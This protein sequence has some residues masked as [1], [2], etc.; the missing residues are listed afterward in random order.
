MKMKRLKMLMLTICMLPVAL[1][2]T[3]CG[4]LSESQLR[5]VLEGME[6]EVNVNCG[7]TTPIMTIQSG[8]FQVV[9][10]TQV[11]T[12]VFGGPGIYAI[13]TFNSNMTDSEIIAELERGYGMPI[14]DIW[15]L[16]TLTLN[17][18]TLEDYKQREIDDVRN[19][20]D[21][22]M[23]IIANL[24]I[25]FDMGFTYTVDAFGKIHLRNETV[26]ATH[27]GDFLM[28]YIDGTI[29]LSASMWY[30]GQFVRAVVFVLE[31]V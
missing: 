11:R 26:A 2:L 14:E 20:F 21:S 27:F 25:F 29:N 30:D 12:D 4:G 19:T 16:N 9:E 17:P 3:A 7:H 23:E 22:R 8:S 10:F 18:G 13:V 31:R 5:D 6:R 28:T 15:K 24:I 1:V